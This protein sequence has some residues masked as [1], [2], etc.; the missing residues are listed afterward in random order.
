MTWLERVIEVFLSG[1]AHNWPYLVVGIVLAAAADAFLDRRQF[2]IGA[3]RFE[4]LA[5]AAATAL[6][7]L[8]PLCSCGTVAVLLSLLATGLPWAPVMA[9]LVS[10][11]LMSPAIYALTAGALGQSM[12]LARLGAAVGLGL[13]A[14][15]FTL[16]LERRS[17]VRPYRAPGARAAAG[18]ALPGFGGPAGGRPTPACA[19]AAAPAGPA[20]GEEPPRG[21]VAAAKAAIAA[22]RGP[23]PAPGRCG[24]GTGVRPRPPGTLSRLWPAVVRQGRFVLGYFAVFSLL[25]AIVEVSLPAAWV[26]AL[27]GR[28]PAASVPLAAALGVPLYVSGVAAVPLVASL[29]AMGMGKGAALAFMI[30]GPGTHV[31][32]VT[33]VALIAPRRLLWFYL[34]LVFLGALGAGYIYQW[35]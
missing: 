30:A 20:A 29:Q 28:Y 4:G 21:T 8:T 16:G 18:Q 11:P 13:A 19:C 26:H 7:A 22:A 34:A 33:A 9:F 35:V 27:F 10:S 2:M 15:F 32:A 1:F 31:G 3:G 17:W 6:G 24:C 25:A 12:A 5:V 23:E 14:G